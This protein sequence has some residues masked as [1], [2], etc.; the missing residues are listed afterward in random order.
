M[1]KATNE[2]DYANYKSLTS[3][4]LSVKRITD[5]VNETSRA[6]ENAATKK[7]LG[8]RVTDWKGH[9]PEQFG[10]LLLDD[11]LVATKSGSDRDYHVFLFEKMLLCCKDVSRFSDLAYLK[12]LSD[13][14]L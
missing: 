6:K 8:N 9:D 14:S 1:V 13:L 5:R 2:S 3:G 7:E 12:A 10:D 4:L 11:Q